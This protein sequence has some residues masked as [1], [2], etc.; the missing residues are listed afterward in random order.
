[1]SRNDGNEAATLGRKVDVG[2]FFR[3]DVILGEI[4]GSFGRLW[5]AFQM[6]LVVLAVSSSVKHL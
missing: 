5:A 1:M 2:G 4:F 6:D 3:S